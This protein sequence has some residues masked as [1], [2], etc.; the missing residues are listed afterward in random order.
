MC[1][2]MERKS[3]NCLAFLYTGEGRCPWQPKE[4]ADELWFYAICWRTYHKYLGKNYS[5]MLW[6]FTIV[7]IPSWGRP[8]WCLLPPHTVPATN[9]SAFST[10]F[11]LGSQRVCWAYLQSMG[12][13]LLEG[14]K[15]FL[16]VT[17]EQPHE[18]SSLSMDDGFSMTTFL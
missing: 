13:G 14:E 8:E 5:E 2:V 16:C 15:R 9:H 6:Q 1:D 18:K 7:I 3:F 11:T 17:P 12:R 4:R 10:H